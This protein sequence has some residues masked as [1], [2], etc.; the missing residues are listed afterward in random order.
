[1][2]NEIKKTNKISWSKGG[3]EILLLVD[4]TIDQTGEQAT[5]AVQIIGGTSEVIDFVD[6]A[7]P[8]HVAFKNLNKKW[9]ALTTL[10]KA[11]Y[12]DEADYNTKNTVYV[13]TAN[14]TTAINATYSITPGGGNG[15]FIALSIAFYAC[16]ATD[17]VN[18]LVVGIEV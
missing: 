18:L 2:A 12:T 17:N 16:K 11:D 13:G 8:A 9:S 3:A 10:Q 14:P 4:E 5:E 15:P 6:V 1:M 7:A